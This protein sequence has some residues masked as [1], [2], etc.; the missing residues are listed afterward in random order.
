MGEMSKI[1][2]R[3]I[4]LNLLPA[5]EALLATGSVGEAARRMFVSQSA[6]SHSLAKLREIFGDPLLVTSGRRLVMTPLAERLSREIGAALDGLDRAVSL[7]E[8]FDPV[9]SKRVFR[10]ATVDY[11]ELTALPDLMALLSTIAPGVGIEIERL[12]PSIFPLLVAGEIDLALLGDSAQVPL[13]GL[14]RATL[15]DHAFSV[16]VRPDHP[17]V[18]RKLDLETYLDL[19]HILV[20]VEGRRDG[21]VDRALAKIGRTRRIAL[22]VPHFVT[23]PLAVLHSDHVCTIASSVAERAEALFGLRVLPPPLDVPPAA[24]IALWSRLRDEDEGGKWFRS[25]FLAEDGLL[26]Q[27]RRASA[28][29]APMRARTRSNA[30]RA[31]ARV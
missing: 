2:V 19:G 30:R 21:A 18:R 20:S 25:L 6:M 27:R 12:S 4:N 28:K 10:I 11:F 9:K 23:A 17:R 8:P 7:P 16:I 31:R 5:L 3:A 15:F 1:D 24:V 14:R 26:R 29:V 13:A 22:R